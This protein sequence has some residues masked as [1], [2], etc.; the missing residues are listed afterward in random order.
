MADEIPP[1]F[2]GPDPFHCAACGWGW[3]A[4]TSMD[5]VDRPYTVGQPCPGCGVWNQICILGPGHD[6]EVHPRASVMESRVID[7]RPLRAIESSDPTW[8]ALAEAIRDMPPEEPA[9]EVTL[10]RVYRRLTGK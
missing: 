10:R 1:G 7:N 3:G 5:S 2:N 9:D 8:G 4:R 6:G